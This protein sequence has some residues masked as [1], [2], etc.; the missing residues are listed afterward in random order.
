M[1]LSREEDF[2]RKTSILHFLPQNYLPLGWG[3]SWNL[4]FFVSL[5]YKCYIPN[6]VKIGP[7]VLEK[8]LTDDRRRTIT[9]HE[10]LRWPKERNKFLFKTKG[11]LDTTLT[12]HNIMWLQCI[13]VTVILVNLESPYIPVNLQQLL[14]GR[15]PT[16][17]LSKVG[18]F[19]RRLF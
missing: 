14:R 7:A 4:Q 6:L 9:T 5:L 16:F 8:M 3:G 18:D 10:W 15:S 19:A 11:P 1:P 17:Q 2:L 13:K 12:I